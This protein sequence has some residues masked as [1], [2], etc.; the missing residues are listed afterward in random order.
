MQNEE[1][2]FDFMAAAEET[3][4]Q[5]DEMIKRIPGD[6][7]AVLAEEWRKS[8]WLAELPKA[9]NGVATAAERTEAAA[10][11]LTRK[12]TRAGFAVCLG[13]VVIPLLIWGYAYLQTGKLRVERENL[14]V[15]TS[16]LEGMIALMKGET[17]GGATFY[18]GSDGN[19]I[20]ALPD[21]VEFDKIGKDFQGRS[22]AS[23]VPLR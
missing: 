4:K 5:L 14:T 11:V 3:G 10:I 23:Y 15:E 9:A 22:A 8:S 17:G 20:F 6:M 13:A 7:K 2:V 1:Q 21:G 18:K 16:R 19:W 12:A